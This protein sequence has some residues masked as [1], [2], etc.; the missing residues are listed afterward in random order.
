M[1]YNKLTVLR[2]NIEALK[3][4]FQHKRQE[5]SAPLTPQEK[6]TLMKYKGFGGLSFILN[7][8]DD[9]SKWS[10]SEQGT[11]FEQTNAL[12]RLIKENSP[13]ETASAR[14]WMS[15]K[16]SVLTSFYTPVKVSNAIVGTVNELVKSQ[17]SAKST[18]GKAKGF[19]NILDPSAGLGAFVASPVFTETDSERVAIEKD[20]LTAEILQLLYPEI[21][22]ENKGFEDFNPAMVTPDGFDFVTSNIPFGDVSVFD[23][24]FSKS[25]DRRLIQS[26]SKIHNYFFAKGL[27]STREGGLLAFVTSRGVM[28]SEYNY[29]IR[30]YLMSNSHLISAI[31]LPDGM[32]SDNAGTE[33]GTDLIILQ[34]ETGKAFNTDDEDLFL[35]STSVPQADGVLVDFF[36][37]G[38]YNEDDNP[39]YKSHLPESVH[40]IKGTD[41]YGKNTYLY[42]Y[43]GSNEGL[44]EEISAIIKRDFQEKFDTNLYL[45]HY[46]EKESRAK[47]VFES[48]IP[49]RFRGQEKKKVVKGYVPKRTGSAYNL[50]PVGLAKQVPPIG[51][52]QEDTPIKDV[53]AYGRYFHPMSAY[54]SYITEYDPEKQ[55]A[56]GLTNLGY[57]WEF[58]SMSLKEMD[59]VEVRGL[60]IERDLSFKPTTLGEIR[61]L[62]EFIRAFSVTESEVVEAELVFE[63]GLSPDISSDQ[64]EESPALGIEFGDGIADEHDLDQWDYKAAMEDLVPKE[65]AVQIPK[66][67]A[68]ERTPLGDRT[69]YVHLE[70]YGNNLS[71]YILEYDASYEHAFGLKRSGEFGEFELGYFSMKE[72][73]LMNEDG[74]STVRDLRFRPSA[75][76]DIVELRGFVAP[77]LALAPNETK[78]QPLFKEDAGQSVSGEQSAIQAEEEQH[79][80]TTLRQGPAVID[81]NEGKEYYFSGDGFGLK[82]EDPIEAVKEVAQKNGAEILAPEDGENRED[83]ENKDD[84]E[85][86]VS[87]SHSQPSPKA[88]PMG[89]VSEVDRIINAAKKIKEEVTVKAQGRYV[90]RKKLADAVKGARVGL[91]AFMASEP[92]EPTNLFQDISDAETIGERKPGA[93][94]DSP[95]VSEQDELSKQIR[96]A[97]KSYVTEERSQTQSQTQ[98][99]SQS[100]SLKRDT[101][102]GEDAGVPEIDFSN[103]LTEMQMD[104]AIPEYLDL[105]KEALAVDEATGTVGVLFNPDKGTR[106]GWFKPLDPEDKKEY[107]HLY[108]YVRLRDAYYRLYYKE[109]TLREAQTKDRETLNTLYDRFVKKYGYLNSFKESRVL[110]GQD[111]LFTTFSYA[112]LVERTETGKKSRKYEYKYTKSDIFREP[113]AFNETNKADINTASDALFVSL[114]RTGNVDL[115]LI[116]S[117]VPELS[118]EQVISQLDGQIYYD[119]F[120]N[121]FFPREV[122]LK[123]NAYEK[124]DRFERYN[125]ENPGNPDVERSIEGLRLAIPPQVPFPDIQINLGERWVD[126]SLYNE[127]AHW[128]FDDNSFSIVHRGTAEISEYFVEDYAPHAHKMGGSYLIAK[129]YSVKTAGRRFYNGLD[130]LQYAM[131]DD[132]PDMKVTKKVLNPLTGEI[133]ERK[134]PDIVGLRKFEETVEKIRS[135]F[136]SWLNALPMERKEELTKKYNY[137]FNNEPKIRY[138]GSHQTFPDLMFKNFNYDSLYKSQMDAVWM[139]KMNEG[140]II[141][142]EVG[143]GKTMIMVTASYEMKRLGL[144]DKPVIIALK[145]NVTDI[146]E[147]YR[148]AYPG[149]KVLAPEE[150]EYTGDNKDV[151][152]NKVKNN[153]W[154]CIIMTHEQFSAIPH[155][156]EVQKR[157]LR[158]QIKDLEDTI[159]SIDDTRVTKRQLKGLESRKIKLEKDF[160]ELIRK[161]DNKKAKVADFQSLGID[162]IFID[163]SHKFKTLSYSTHHNRV[164]GLGPEDGS[165]KADHLLMAI[166]TIQERKGKDLCATFV[167]GTTIK[168]SITEL[169]ILFK[170][171]RPRELEKQGLTTFDA[172]ARVY[173]EKSTEYEFSVT[174]EIKLKD[175]FRRFMKAPELGAF[176]SNI[177]D[178]RLVK[179]IG[180]ERP[181]KNITLYK[182]PQTE[183]QKDFLAR[184]IKYAETGDAGLVGRGLETENQKKARMLLVT[185]LAGK[186]SLDMRI[187]DPEYE[188]D[189]DNKLSHCARNI[190]RLYHQYNE[191]K[192]TQ[193]VFCDTGIPNKDKEFDVYTELKRKLVEDYEIPEKEV[194]FMTSN[195]SKD[196]RKRMCDRLNSGDVRVIIGGTTT[197]GTGINAQERAVAVH[198]LDVPWVP[199]D[200]E[201]RNG[202]AVRAGNW[203]ARDHANNEVQIYNYAT[204]RSLDAYKFSLLN[205]KQNFISQL[206]TNTVGSRILDEGL[207]EMNEDDNGN[208]QGMVNYAEF[209]AI[210]S[211]DTGLLEKTKIE[212]E[213]QILEAQKSSINNERWYAE[214]KIRQGKEQISK[215]EGIIEKTKSDLEV[216]NSRLEWTDDGEIVNKLTI[217]GVEDNSDLKQV[218]DKLTEIEETAKT[219]GTYKHIGDIYGFPIFVKTLMI[220]T[221]G[222]LPI[223]ENRFYVRGQE[224]GTPDGLNKNKTI[225]YTYNN[226]LL[227]NDPKLKVANFLN[228]LKKMP[229]LV[230][231]HEGKLE[232]ARKDLKIDTDLLEKTQFPYEEKLAGLKADLKV[233][234]AKIDANLKKNSVPPGMEEANASATVRNDRSISEQSSYDDNGYGYEDDENDYGYGR[235]P[236]RGR[237]W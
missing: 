207:F 82:A 214:E 173:A 160:K 84:K 158:E 39:D 220:A 201:Q 94:A 152:L 55:I 131:Q 34:K 172:W 117:L 38:L 74:I 106:T 122:F 225:F 147:T 234:I 133:E 169:Y 16:Q 116:Q 91:F 203:V 118:K 69:A 46:Q 166:R 127:F 199:S 136:S 125:A 208:S 53:V 48:L 112:E 200:M 151:F 194:A 88:S 167:S 1:A 219:Q 144:I 227:A 77:H 33:V 67:S 108:D 60:G 232:K 3:V 164:S 177:T 189:V 96:A 36:L 140:G 171:L 165:Q 76:K 230:E 113:V 44:A 124:L 229:S 134:E 66:L 192:G 141:D 81:R 7:P 102:T 121:K 213:I 226:G 24:R 193:F 105:V 222:Q 236:G 196:K 18:D 83:K 114:D 51:A 107:L 202:R 104:F 25:K 70:N 216:F 143:G 30:E 22:V 148:K 56:F 142:H 85:E 156:D 52:A 237:R 198:H 75:L 111:D 174:N 80:V 209:V 17:T 187:V 186:M 37:N 54:T 138:D 188:D 10:K 50:M 97:I 120:E 103:L 119:P 98:N 71:C 130:M 115:D 5:Y 190:D 212:R 157:F 32:F 153:N 31:R 218:A 139:L 4:L 73:R 132:R 100:Q 178:F 204:D 161:L 95:S 110:K 15:I 149:A 13:D 224:E 9:E 47:S 180:L 150:G 163:E 129:E 195:L 197:L 146:V 27:E 29:F 135:K 159:L 183:T 62:S 191:W 40:R 86:S 128:L 182:V 154:D 205:T 221:A 21:K 49:A 59:K 99:Q 2:N 231:S 217:Y 42:K 65:L 72:L 206:K 8:L 93:G 87:R 181:N 79:Q 43:F 162:H 109:A 20:P 235:K 11:L 179:D 6:K 19:Q 145:A 14:Y 126:L 155:S 64:N 101:Q 90:S 26:Q 137:L 12:Y 233:V 92:E 168:N 35:M 211:G 170:Y 63:A 57:G 28:D 61:E 123:C 176:Y 184:L 23:E 223:I 45:N 78:E 228:A 41:P 215:L 175:R 58:G 210:V 89:A 68:T 185:D